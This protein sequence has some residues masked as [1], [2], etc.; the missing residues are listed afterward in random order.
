MRI[1]KITLVFCLFQLV[2]GCNSKSSQQLKLQ[3]G[4]S[5]NPLREKL[6]IPTID[7]AMIKSESRSFGHTRWES[8][9][10]IPK[11]GEVLHQWKNFQPYIDNDSIVEEHDG[12]RI[13]INDSV[14]QGINIFSRIKFDSIVTRSGVLFNY[15]L[16]HPNS[17]ALASP[18]KELD[19][20]QIDSVFREW[21]LYYLIWND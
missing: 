18:F 5:A 19:E 12:F 7:S 1:F 20:K 15:S 2:L 8:K 9:Q 11:D 6:R 4:Y 13:K 10:E 16:S 17:D 14:G 3:D 21:K